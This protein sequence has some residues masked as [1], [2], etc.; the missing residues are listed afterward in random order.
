LS[1]HQRIMIKFMYVTNIGYINKIQ[2]I[3]T[4]YNKNNN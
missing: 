1:D 4:F 2:P 3:N